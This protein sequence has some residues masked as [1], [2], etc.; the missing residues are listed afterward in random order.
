M[1]WVPGPAASRPWL[2][3]NESA[4]SLVFRR[5][6]RERGFL[7]VQTIVGRRWA[8]Q[9][10][11]L[12]SSEFGSGIFLLD[13]CRHRALSLAISQT[14]DHAGLDVSVRHFDFNLESSRPT[15]DGQIF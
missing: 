1:V 11:D 5:E 7:Q 6:S 10:V 15:D 14:M 13:Q 12:P 8:L 9:Q 3:R 2:S 4:A